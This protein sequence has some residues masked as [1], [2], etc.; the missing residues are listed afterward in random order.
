MAWARSQM[1]IEG[2]DGKIQEKKGF[3]ETDG[4]RNQ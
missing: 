2:E 1:N 3:E 4:L